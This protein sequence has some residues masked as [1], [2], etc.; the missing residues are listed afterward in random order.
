MDAVAQA[1]SDALDK[2]KSAGL[3]KVQ[4]KA[5]DAKAKAK[6]QAPAKAKGQAPA[7]A[8]G[9]ATRKGNA[10]AK[11]ALVLGCCKC[12]GAAIGCAQ[13]RSDKFGGKRGPR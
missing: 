4:T 1:V 5:K 10:K 8:K 2:K 11:S 9:Q 13:C 3:G 7:K 6:G 12:R